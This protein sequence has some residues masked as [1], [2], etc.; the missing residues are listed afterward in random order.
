MC[1]RK[2][3]RREAGTREALCADKRHNSK[4]IMV[5]HNF[6]YSEKEVK[7]STERDKL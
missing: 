3:F 5:R 7:L 2:E 1:R 4:S 6:Q